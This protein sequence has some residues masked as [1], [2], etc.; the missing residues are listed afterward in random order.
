MKRIFSVLL[1]SVLILS[2]AVGCSNK[3]VEVEEL[4]LSTVSEENNNQTVETSQ[5]NNEQKNEEIDYILYLKMKNMPFLYDEMF[6]IDINDQRFKDKTIEEF[7]LTELLNYKSN[8]QLINPIP[9]GTKILS[10]EREDN[11]VVVN[12]SKEFIERKMSTGD[13][14]LT[15]GSIVNSLI[16]IPGNETV[17][18]KVEGELLKEYY[19]FDTSKPIAFLEGL[20][21]DK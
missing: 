14:T 8:D 10:I 16:A 13:A 20:F 19:G 18:I 9:E 7:V 21:P 17:Q 15:I 3:K 2:L 12:F 6:S 11:N 4:E 5:N 1:T